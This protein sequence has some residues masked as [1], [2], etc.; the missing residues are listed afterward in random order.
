HFWR[1]VLTSGNR[2]LRLASLLGLVMASIGFVL[3][4]VL[5]V[6]RALNQITVAGW[7]SVIVA[8]LLGTGAVLVT[9]GIIAEYVGVATKMAM[10]RPLYLI[11]SD[12]ATTALGREARRAEK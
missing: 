7:T 6:R 11:T 12:P 3:A 8:I 2:P 9:L 1:L 4:L 10:G 5:L